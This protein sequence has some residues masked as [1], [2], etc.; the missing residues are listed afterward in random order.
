M[1]T[2]TAL[3]IVVLTFVALYTA[4]KVEGLQWLLG[5]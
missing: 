2:R 1:R 4:T 5:M 3:L